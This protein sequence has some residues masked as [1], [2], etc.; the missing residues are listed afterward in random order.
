M[1]QH[2]QACSTFSI[3]LHD[4]WPRA[5]TDGAMTKFRGSLLRLW[6]HAG[7]KRTG[8]AL[9]QHSGW[10]TLS[11]GAEHRTSPRKWSVL[12][13]GCKCSMRAD[14]DTAEVPNRVHHILSNT[15][16]HPMVHFCL[17]CVNDICGKKERRQPLRERKTNTEN[18]ELSAEKWGGKLPPICFIGTS[19]QC[20]LKSAG[21]HLGWGKKWSGSWQRWLYTGAS[22][23]G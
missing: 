11:W 14:L 9:H 4:S 5:E 21:S 17:G 8:V 22:G 13:L 10:S 20:L 16:H 6:K 3:C 23:C 12:A 2:I 1:I 19:T 15:R 18:R 7:W